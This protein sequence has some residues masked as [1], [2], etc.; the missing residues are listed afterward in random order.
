MAC[1][2]RPISV[3]LRVAYRRIPSIGPPPVGRTPIYV[4]VMACGSGTARR[5]SHETR[6]PGRRVGQ[7][8]SVRQLGP[9]KAVLP[10]GFFATSLVMQITP[11]LIGSLPRSSAGWL[12]RN[13][14]CGPKNRWLPDWQLA[15]RGVCKGLRILMGMPGRKSFA[16]SRPGVCSRTHE[17]IGNTAM[18]RPSRS[19]VFVPTADQVTESRGWY[20]PIITTTTSPRRARPSSGSSPIA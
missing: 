9:T 14:D 3:F 2:A 11:T 12:S 13:L 7:L 16:L 17:R 15:T 8:N 18:E 4:R 5:K 1:S 19:L 10:G 6:N 20:D